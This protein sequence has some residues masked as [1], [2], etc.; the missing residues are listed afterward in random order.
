MK[1]N[2]VYY[3]IIAVFQIIIVLSYLPLQSA[4]KKYADNIIE[5]EAD[6][7]W[8]MLIAKRD[9]LLAGKLI[10]VLY[11]N[12]TPKYDIIT[13]E[14]KDYLSS[15][16]TEGLDFH[17]NMYL[18]NPTFMGEEK[19]SLNWL[20]YTI[21]DYNISKGHDKYAPLH[22]TNLKGWF[23][24]GWALG[25]AH[26]SGSEYVCYIAHPYILDLGRMRIMYIPFVKC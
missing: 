1:R 10:C 11:H 26:S 17:D 13:S 20:C 7:S 23:Q 18:F 21:T 5:E 15:Y 9:S 3:T 2:V 16:I 24:S 12:T 4:L 6:N 25:Y 19:Y 22:D 14:E 8:N